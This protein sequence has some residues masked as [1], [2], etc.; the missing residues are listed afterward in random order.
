MAVQETVPRVERMDARAE[1]ERLERLADLMDSRFYIPG[2]PLRFGLD[3]VLGLVPG[4][5]DAA[6]AL[7]A[8]YLIHRAQQLGVPQPVLAR[9][10]ANLGI[11]LV[12]GSIPLVGDLFDLGFKSNRKNVALL[13]RHV[14]EQE[15][16]G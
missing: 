3:S 2:T 11:D 12:L 7:P 15:R 9:M 6:T 4:V 1:I 8:A 16:L 5:G 14:E 13:R 10:V